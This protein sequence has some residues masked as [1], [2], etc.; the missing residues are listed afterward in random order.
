MLRIHGLNQHFRDRRILRDVGFD[1][2]KGSMHCIVGHS[3]M[4]KTTLLKCIMGLVPIT[5]GRILL[6][7]EDLT[8]TRPDARVRSGLGYVSQT[9][10]V[11]PRLTVEEN[12]ALP[13]VTRRASAIPEHVYQLFPDLVDLRRRRGGELAHGRQRQLAIARALVLEPRILLLDAPTHGLRSDMTGKIG[14][15]LRVLNRERGLT[16]LLAERK[17]SFARVTADHFTILHHGRTVAAGA[18]G[19][20]DDA[21]VR[22]YLKA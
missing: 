11:F 15:V 10:E 12:L 20:L 17:L 8:H 5:S 4:G 7:D 1:L 16:I 21:L 14:E 3:G 19:V 22:Q 9:H 13:L 18:M 2:Q 6:C